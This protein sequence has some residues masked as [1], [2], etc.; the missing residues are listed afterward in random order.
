MLTRFAGLFG[1]L[2]PIITLT[3]IFISI[4][5][6]SWFDWHNNALSDLGVSTTPNPFNAA[7]VIGGVLYLVFVIGFLRWQGCASRL[8]KLGAFFLLAGGLGLGLIGIFAEDT[9]RIHYIVAATYFLA[10]PLAYGLFG[11]DLLKRGERVSGVLTLAAGAA[12]F[13]LIAF[14]PHKRI[15]VP[16][17]LA[18]IIIATWTFSIGVKM[19]IEPENKH[20]QTQPTIQR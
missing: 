2:T 15:A 20:E 5:L 19:L 10:T 6:S 16:E 14:V 11:T 18:A 8:A 13:S 9:G 3:L 17:I 12:A 1:L 7:L 4:S